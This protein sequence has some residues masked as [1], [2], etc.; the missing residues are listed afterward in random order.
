MRT[1]ASPSPPAESLAHS[2]SADATV[3]ERTSENYSGEKVSDFIFRDPR[4]HTAVQNNFLLQKCSM[5]AGG[6]DNAF[7]GK[8]DRN[9]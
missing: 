3:P 7:Y 6:D 1:E 9:S 8:A 5:Q 2:D 4:S